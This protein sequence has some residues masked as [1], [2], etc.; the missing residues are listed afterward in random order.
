MLIPF[1]CVLP[2]RS[3]EF[4]QWCALVR[5]SPFCLT[6]SV[7]TF[8]PKAPQNHSPRDI[9]TLT[10]FWCYRLSFVAYRS[11][12]GQFARGVRVGP[13]ARMPRL[14]ALYRPKRKWKLA[15]QASPLDDLEEEAS[16]G[17]LWRPNSHRGSMSTE[18]KCLIPGLE[19]RDKSRGERFPVSDDSPP[20]ARMRLRA[21]RATQESFP[22][23]DASLPV[24]HLELPGSRDARG[25]STHDRGATLRNLRHERERERERE[26]RGSVEFPAAHEL[27]R[28]TES[29]DPLCLSGDSI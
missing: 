18:E 6:F 26:V 25:R 3:V 8:R 21:R 24:C 2:G 10:T 15:S 1:P 11:R 27:P 9:H 17:T 5:C 12:I 22:V 4:C 16:A 7:R 19:G 13:G 29:E 23:S 20:A 14:P 28:E